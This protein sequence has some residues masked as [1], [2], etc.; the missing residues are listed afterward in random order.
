[1]SSNLSAAL[2]F[3]LLKVISAS[4]AML[5]HSVSVFL[6]LKGASFLSKVLPN[7]LSTIL[8]TASCVPS[9]LFFKDLSMPNTLSCILDFASCVPFSVASVGSVSSLD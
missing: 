1:M 7:L 6:E 3:G 4:I 9:S 2:S 5:S 8:E